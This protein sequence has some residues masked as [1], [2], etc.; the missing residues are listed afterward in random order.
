VIDVWLVIAATCSALSLQSKECVVSHL[1]KRDL[2]PGKRPRSH[3][4]NGSLARPGECNAAGAVKLMS[5]GCVTS[6]SGH[7]PV[8][9]PGVSR[10]RLCEG[11]FRYPLSARDRCVIGFL[12][13]CWAGCLADFWWWWLEPAHWVS[14]AGC[15][16]NSIVLFYFTCYPLFFVMAVNRLRKVRRSAPV[17]PLRVAFI[18]TRAPSEPWDVARATLIAMLHQDFPM[19]YDVWLADERPDDEILR[20]CQDNGVAMSCRYGVPEYHRPDWPRRTKCKEGNLA[21]FY[22]HWGY[23]DYDV[24]A[25]LDCDHR[26]SPTYLAEMVRPFADPAIGYVAAPSVCDT[27]A[28]NSWSARGRLYREATFHGA[29]QLGHSGGWAPACIG[30]HYAVRT[31]AL[32]EIGG[33]GPELAEDLSTTFLLNSAGWHGAFAIDAE[34]H[35]DGPDTFA[36]MLVQEFQ[37]SRSLTVILLRLVPHNIWRL[38]LSLRIRFVYALLFYGLL[39]TSTLGGIVL[40]PSAAI[41][42][43][44]WVSIN[45]LAFLAHWWSLSAW[46]IGVTLLLRRRGLLRPPEAPIVSWENWLYSLTRWPYIAL[47]IAAALLHLV[48]P[49]AHSFKVTPKGVAGLDSLSVRLTIPY[50]LI[51]VCCSAAAVVGENTGGVTGYVFLCIIAAL[52]YSMVAI[53]VPILHAREMTVRASVSTGQALRRTSFMPLMLGILSILPVAY[54]AT[55]YPPYAEQV[56]R[57]GWSALPKWHWQ[58][59]SLL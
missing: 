59:R 33:L 17:P 31:A 11:T 18:V 38:P 28:A 14:T 32:R 40:A 26:P 41:A 58:W 19:A 15:V 53:L 20:W 34:A 52:I 29:F 30:S 10:R 7:G 4:G 9:S 2:A 3:I 13:L 48:R 36:A 21:F 55:R 47:G 45:Y 51:S 44:P 50:I 56:M 43:K 22:D 24:V 49:R 42:G 54:V 25:Q 37:W 12:S 39:V 23:R 6:V 16:A 57:D 5:L 8:I 27:N 1:T 35:G 46:L